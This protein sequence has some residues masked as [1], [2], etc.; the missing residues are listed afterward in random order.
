M[1]NDGVTADV[2]P[3]STE[4]VTADDRLR[5]AERIARTSCANEPATWALSECSLPIVPLGPGKRL[6]RAP[7]QDTLENCNSAVD[8]WTGMSFSGRSRF[9]FSKNAAIAVDLIP[10]ATGS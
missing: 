5:H 4:L 7:N 3:T 6:A 10:G 1:R 8:T 9:D 2:Q